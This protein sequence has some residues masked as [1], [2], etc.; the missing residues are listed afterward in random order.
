MPQP[1]KNLPGKIYPLLILTAFKRITSNP[2]KCA[3]GGLPNIQ[4][5]IFC[6]N[7]EMQS[8]HVSY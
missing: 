6:K 7:K 1:L 5:T 8:S 3:Y 4:Y 2:N